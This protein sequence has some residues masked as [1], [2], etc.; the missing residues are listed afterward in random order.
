MTRQIQGF[1]GITVGCQGPGQA[2]KGAAVAAD[3]MNTDH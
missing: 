2:L 3:T 1:H